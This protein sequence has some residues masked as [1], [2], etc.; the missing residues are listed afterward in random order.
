MGPIP[1]EG[2]GWGQPHQLRQDPV[3]GLLILILQVF[4]FCLTEV[5]FLMQMC[6]FCVCVCGGGMWCAW[7]ACVCTLPSHRCSGCKEKPA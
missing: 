5:S 3:L 7:G 2:V 4:A 1:G 6:P